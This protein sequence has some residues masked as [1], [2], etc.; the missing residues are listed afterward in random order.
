MLVNTFTKTNGMLEAKCF[1]LKRFINHMKFSQ[2]NK[3]LEAVELRVNDSSKG[4]ILI[5]TLNA[6]K[7]TCLLVELLEKVKSRFSFLDRRVSEI[8]S[9]LVK[10]AQRFMN[11]I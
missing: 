1:L 6:V 9:K 8:R 2:A 10:I 3:F 4:N 7:A 5:L 11:D